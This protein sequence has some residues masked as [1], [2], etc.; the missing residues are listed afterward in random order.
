MLFM[1][2]FHQRDENLLHLLIARVLFFRL[3]LSKVQGILGLFFVAYQQENIIKSSQL[4][5]NMVLNTR[6]AVGLDY[7]Y[8]Q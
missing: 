8:H 5:Q 2:I 3:F 4:L 1:G 6:R 7:Y